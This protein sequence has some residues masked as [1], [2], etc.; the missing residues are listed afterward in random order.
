[1]MNPEPIMSIDSA[2]IYETP[3]GGLHVAYHIVDAPEDSHIEIPP[4]VMRMARMAQGNGSN[5]L[6][7]LRGMAGL[8]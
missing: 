4:A 8:G 6:T 3:A 5:P 1:M 2:K 7:M